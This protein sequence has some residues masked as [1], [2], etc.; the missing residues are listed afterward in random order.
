[1]K[2][3]IG[4]GL[5]G[6][7]V[8]CST[9]GTGC[10]DPAGP[11]EGS[12]AVLF[13]G[14]S[15][16]YTN[17]LPGLVGRLMVEAGHADFYVES[18]AH[19]GYGLQDHWATGEAVDRIASGHWDVVVLQQGP[20]ATEGRPSLLYFG[21]LFAQRIR[22]SGAR[23]AMLM[24]WPDTVRFFDFDGV[25]DSYRTAADHIDGLFFPAG[26]AWR[27][28]WKRDPT[29]ALYGPDGF[30]PSLLGSYLAALV[31]FQQ[32]A[33][34]SPIGLPPRIPVGRGSVELAPDVARALQE[35][36]AEANELWA[37]GQ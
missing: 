21:D 17:D 18:V 9:A 6:L 16:T 3:R 26:E 37:R 29:L 1:M 24:V 7:V 34:V 8:T 4:A 11:P 10:S 35:A 14:N 27:L 2:T 19:P 13:V 36:A 23:P 32:L 33:G 22:A 12:Y 20:S 25:L 31:I 28:A 30:H 15:L 5:L